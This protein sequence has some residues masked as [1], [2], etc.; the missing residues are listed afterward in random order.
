MKRI[1]VAMFILLFVASAGLFAADTAKKKQ[2]PKGSI[3]FVTVTPV[4]TDKAIG[5]RTAQSSMYHVVNRNAARGIKTATINSDTI[6][7]ARKKPKK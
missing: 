4:L 2:P 6:N 7:G 1:V 5:N 3:K